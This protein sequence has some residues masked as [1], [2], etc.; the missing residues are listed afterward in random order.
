MPACRTVSVDLRFEE[1]E[2]DELHDIGADGG[3][4]QDGCSWESPE[5]VRVVGWSLGRKA[6]WR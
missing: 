4:R 3:G 5:S 1:D 2:L 6:D